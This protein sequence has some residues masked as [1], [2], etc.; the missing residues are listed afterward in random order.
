MKQQQPRVRS[1]L[2]LFL[3]ADCRIIPSSYMLE[4]V[5]GDNCLFVGPLKKVQP[6]EVAE[7][8]N[9][10]LV[11]MGNGTVSKSRV[12]KVMSE[13]FRNTSY[14]I[15]I[16]GMSTQEDDDNIHMAPRFDFFELFPKTTVFI[17]H[18]G[19]NSIMDGFIYG[20]PH[21]VCPGKNFERKYNANSVEKNKTGITIGLSEFRTDVIK[22]A[23]DQLVFK[24]SF[25]KNAENL[26]NH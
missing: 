15:F 20:I 17:N 12:R 8:K 22:D 11:Y 16:A 25:H 6:Y 7:H 2:D 4:S 26:A 14:E 13:V 5:S 19:Q 3:R 23:I 18:G 24:K 10:I 9:Y 1:A 21:L